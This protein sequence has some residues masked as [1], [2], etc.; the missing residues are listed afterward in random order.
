MKHLCKGHVNGF[1]HLELE[2]LGDQFDLGFKFEQRESEEFRFDAMT[3]IK[4][5]AEPL[6]VLCVS[7]AHGGMPPSATLRYG[8]TRLMFEDDHIVAAEGDRRRLMEKA[9]PH[10]LADARALQTGQQP[11][12]ASKIVML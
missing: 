12:V 9:R 2:E 10:I 11:N 5:W 7:V 1:A 6:L 3:G 4:V 8:L